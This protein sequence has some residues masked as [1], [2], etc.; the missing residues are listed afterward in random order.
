[1]RVKQ[2]SPARSHV[3][4]ERGALRGVL[5]D[6][7]RAEL[8]D[9]GVTGSGDLAKVAG[10]ESAADGGEL[11]VIEDVETFRPE[12]DLA[13]SF[14]AQEEALVEGE[15][16]VVAAGSGQGVVA[17]VAPLPDGRSGKG[18]GVKPSVNRM[19][20]RNRPV[21]VRPVS[22]GSAVRPAVPVR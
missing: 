17:Q 4:G 1:M 14:F 10:R 8:E 2:K 22:S 15:V 6:G 9:S 21:H 12:L 7:F 13:A 20:V 16:P 3:G 11:R 19:R 5:E 18:R